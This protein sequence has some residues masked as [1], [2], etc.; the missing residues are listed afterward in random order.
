MRRLSARSRMASMLASASFGAVQCRDSAAQADLPGFV[1][2]VGDRISGDGGR[3]LLDALRTNGFVIVDLKPAERERLDAAILEFARQ[4]RGFRYPPPPVSELD[5][6]D[7]EALADD[8]NKGAMPLAFQRCF[9]MLY[10]IAI[11]AARQLR[12]S[13][14]QG[15]VAPP[16]ANGTFPFEGEG[17]P[18]PYSSSFFNIFNYDKGC[19]NSHVDRGVLTVVYGIQGEVRGEHAR[20]WLKLPSQRA[21]EE[22][23]AHRWFAPEPGQLLLWGG[24]GLDVQDIPIIEHCVRVDP[25][26]RYIEHSHVTRDPAAQPHGNRV[27]IA[28]V[29]D[30]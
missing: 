3:L 2:H 12:V 1:W 26:G 18:W 10:S 29:L 27:S 14:A 9:N 11:T 15:P 28:L 5:P 16:C 25:Y 8:S 13:N 17:G 7:V 19:L 21:S 4:G 6:I 30:E 20:L 23:D 22:A 24:E